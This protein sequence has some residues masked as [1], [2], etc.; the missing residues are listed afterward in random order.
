MQNIWKKNAKLM[1]I[2]LL[3]IFI[4]SGATYAATTMYQ[5]NIVGYDNTTSGLNSNNVQDALDEVYSAATDYTSLEARVTN[6]ETNFLDK[7]YPV[8]SIFISTSLS[9]TSQVAN[10]LGGTW[11]AYGTGRTLVGIDTSQTEFDT[12]EET[13]GSM[14]HQHIYGIQTLDY[15]AAQIF[16]VSNTGALQ[17]GNG[18][19]VGWTYSSNSYPA[20]A[21]NSIGGGV[22]YFSSLSSYRSI[23]NT[24]ATS[25]LQPY[26]TVYMYKRT[27]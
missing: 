3:D 16:D 18:A 26:I 6:L 23:A 15:W 24:S 11:I 19:A 21:N 1:L 9:T 4:I 5:S 10:T 27:A 13:G 12:I 7:V 25:S 8:G 14:T 2:L 22:L 20:T 17:N